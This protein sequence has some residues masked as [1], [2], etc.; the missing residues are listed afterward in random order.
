LR[1]REG[2]K[3]RGREGEGVIVAKQKERILQNSF[4]RSTVKTETT[5]D[6]RG[7]R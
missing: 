3:E 6:K 7:Q 5:G 2:E 1:G 4:K